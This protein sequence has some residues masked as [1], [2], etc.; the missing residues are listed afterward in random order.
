MASRNHRFASRVFRGVGT[1]ASTKT[2]RTGS[3]AQASRTGPT[4][5][6]ATPG[7]SHAGPRRSASHATDRAIGNGHDRHEHAG[8]HAS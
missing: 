8:N 5:S 6:R 2:S 1:G 3:G 7:D 4:T